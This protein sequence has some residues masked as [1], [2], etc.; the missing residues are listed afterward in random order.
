MA[1]SRTFDKALRA[2]ELFDAGKSCNAIAK[3]LG[4]APSTISAW[5][6]REGLTFPR[7][8]TADAV[9][10]HR[11][12]AAER[13]GQIIERLHARAEHNLTRLESARYKTRIVTG[14]GTL[15]V[16]DDDPMAADELRHSQSI[17]NYLKTA[18]EL[19]ALDNDGGVTD[20]TAML[21]T[22]GKALGV[23]PDD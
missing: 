4:F 22:L 3:E 5:A 6:K 17:T 1:R 20:G 12:S 13:R 15:V 16:E 11:L 2:R 10:T 21:I 18:K 9:D 8:A 23:V 19:A 14:E 7:A